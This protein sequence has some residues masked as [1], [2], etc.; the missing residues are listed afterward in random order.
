M[1]FKA[2]LLKKKLKEEGKTRDELVADLK[3]Q[4]CP[5]HKRTV[6]R[7]L[8]GDNPPKAKDLE[9]IARALNCKPQDFDPFF[10]D[11]G[12][13]EVSIQAHVSAASHNAYELMRLR[14]G[15]TQKQI[16]ELAPVLFAI[17]AA[18]ALKVPDQDNA[19]ERKARMNGRPSTQTEMRRGV[20]D[21]GGKAQ[22]VS[23]EV[24]GKGRQFG[25]I[26]LAGSREQLIEAFRRLA[27]QMEDHLC[28]PADCAHDSASSDLRRLYVDL[29]H[30]EGEPV[31]L[32][33]GV[34][35][36][37]DGHLFE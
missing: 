36:G 21:L 12:L 28:R 7:W 3:K 37:S 6:S 25:E 5:K 23:I 8:A 34:Y 14:Y 11:M 19:L 13:G 17:L 31:Y 10:A 24:D 16:M 30:T 32:S 33:D 9:G 18:H 26:A 27:E 35:L 1:A 29:C 4:G 22:D 2:E 20:Q 15:V